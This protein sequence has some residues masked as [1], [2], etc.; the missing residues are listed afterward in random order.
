MNHSSVVLAR[1]VDRNGM[2]ITVQ[3]GGRAASAA[4]AF[5]PTVGTLLWVRDADLTSGRLSGWWMA[6]DATPEDKAELRAMNNEADIIEAWERSIADYNAALEKVEADR[7]GAWLLA[8]AR[9]AAITEARCGKP[10]LALDAVQPRTAPSPGYSRVAIS[11]SQ[12]GFQVLPQDHPALNIDFH[13]QALHS[14]CTAV[15]RRRLASL[16]EDVTGTCPWCAR[17]NIAARAHM[18]PLHNVRELKDITVQILHGAP[19]VTFDNRR[20]CAVCDHVLDDTTTQPCPVT[21]CAHALE[22]R[23]TRDGIVPGCPVHGPGAVAEE[24]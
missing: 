8:A 14:A 11:R 7:P 9:A 24:E 2:S 18:D 21:G 17:D 22:P 15:S 3:R 13:D 12:D 20:V 23:Y 10:A 6:D 19:L 1:V 4:I 5:L 16:S